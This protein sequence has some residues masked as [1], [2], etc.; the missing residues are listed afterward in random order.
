MKTGSHT[1]V[2]WYLVSFIFLLIFVEF[3]L[4]SQSKFS[5]VSVEKEGI[6][7]DKLSI[8]ESFQ[9]KPLE[10][11]EAII[12]GI[13]HQLYV[14]NSHSVNEAFY[15]SLEKIIYHI[16]QKKALFRLKYLNRRIYYH[17]EKKEIE[18][19]RILL[20]QTFD[21]IDSSHSKDTAEIAIACAYMYLAS[22][23]S[24]E[25]VSNLIKGYMDVNATSKDSNINEKALVIS[26]LTRHFLYQAKYKRAKKLISEFDSIVDVRN[27]EPK[28]WFLE[29]NLNKIFLEIYKKANHKEALK[30]A[31]S[32]SP[33]A[34]YKY[35]P[36]SFK[37]RLM[38]WTGLTYYLNNDNDKAILYYNMATKEY[39]KDDPIY[40]LSALGGINQ[41]LGDLFVKK[42]KY[43]KATQYF[44]TAI[45]NYKKHY[46]NNPNS[47]TIRVLINL[48]RLYIEKNEFKQAKQV[49]EEAK[50]L[51]GFLP[52]DRATFFLA[53]TNHFLGELYN[54]LGSL[55]LA[56]SHFL[57]SL[58][59]TV[60][61]HGQNYYLA[62]QNKYKL[63]NLSFLK[64]DYIE[65]LSTLQGSLQTQFQNQDLTFISQNPIFT[66]S[67]E[68]K[69]QLF[70]ILLLKSII[71]F[72]ISE[73]TFQLNGAYSTL[74]LLEKLLNQRVKTVSSE[75]DKHL[76]LEDSY[77]T[78]ELGMEILYR[79][80]QLEPGQKYLNQ[81]FQWME[82][83]KAFGLKESW[84]KSRNM[85]ANLDSV[86][87]YRLFPRMEKRIALLQEKVRR[88]KLSYAPD[89]LAV[90]AWED[91]LFTLIQRYDS[92]LFQLQT[93]GNIPNS[94][95]TSPDI[96]QIQQKLAP[97]QFLLNYFLS[98]STLH[99]IGMGKDSSFWERIVLPNDFEQKVHTHIY[100]ASN[101]E[102]QQKHVRNPDSLQAFGERSHDLYQVLFPSQINSLLFSKGD[103]LKSLIIVP[104]G[105][106]ALLPFDGLVCSL[107]E[108]EEIAH[109]SQMAYLGDRVPI[110][111]E[112]A[113]SFKAQRKS[114][115]KIA[116]KGFG[117][118]APSYGEG[119][120]YNSQRGTAGQRVI[121]NIKGMRTGAP[122]DPLQ[123]NQEEIREIEQLLQA[124]SFAGKQATRK[125]FKQE[126]SSYD[127]LHLSMHGYSDKVEPKLSGLIFSPCGANGN[128][129]DSSLSEEAIHEAILYA[130]EIANLD[131]N[132]R[133][134][135]LSACQTG[136]GKIQK[137]EGIMS[138]ARAFAL[139]GVPSQIM[140]LWNVDDQATLLLFTQFYQHLLQGDTKDIALWKAKKT[141]R[142]NP[143]YSHPYFW[144]AF[145]LIGDEASMPE[146]QPPSFWKRWGLSLIVSLC[147]MVL[148][149]IAWKY[150]NGKA[151]STE[152]LDSPS[153]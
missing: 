97:G 52:I 47:K 133:L 56:E 132:A 141:L 134:A 1:N 127:I 82:K 57:K 13:L 40:H 62:N 86:A 104:D 73:D 95:S 138:L 20:N 88:S 21:L 30:I 28:Q 87:R 124:K 116:S 112:Y 121:E 130:F 23:M 41:N 5:S 18:R 35:I 4:F 93:S 72:T 122:I 26:I 24:A 152:F 55:G 16:P 49:L 151:V 115:A 92:A 105:I 60:S 17:I 91:S 29:H 111:L 126:A 83:S 147:L 50:N 74:F 66:D 119:R 75:A 81:A 100:A 58:D 118:F 142:E 14:Q 53:L 101:W 135:V 42:R 76:L 3:V 123:F 78:Y 117:G 65:A 109:F 145:V 77:K 39:K 98:D 120:V 25:A 32:A 51:C 31:Q 48:G 113:A 114:K 80:Y 37:A 22:P 69:L 125:R 10:E 27:L 34:N 15:D 89:S 148:S 144:A 2:I 71:Q 7:Y 102:V 150:F 149:G 68:Q 64:R 8:P 70:N 128:C 106:L 136:I 43:E 9:V 107:R 79:A 38:D 19:A 67:L 110:H 46:S 59:Q 11:K 85:G 90:I 6:I 146:I 96:K 137:G 44:Q 33:L 153:S 139:A 63:A 94:I 45:E 129:E 54:E 140:S 12:N 131:L 36:P 61:L 103:P 84:E 143:R 99:L 108:K